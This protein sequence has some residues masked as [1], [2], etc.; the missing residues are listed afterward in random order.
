MLLL[1]HVRIFVS[2]GRKYIPWVACNFLSEDMPAEEETRFG[3]SV[4]RGPSRRGNSMAARILIVDDEVHLARILQFALERSGYE[5]TLA[6]DGN[7]A[8]KIAKSER[9]ALVILDLM[10]PGIDGYKVCN[11]LKRDAQFEGVPV[12]LVSARDVEKEHIEEKITAD[13]F[14]AKPFDI[15]YLLESVSQLIGRRVN[16]A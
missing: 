15:N 3:R 13:R 5:V 9:P 10:L 2:I 14:I 7:E 6:F 4:R 12:I 11:M 16:E 1:Y 8:L